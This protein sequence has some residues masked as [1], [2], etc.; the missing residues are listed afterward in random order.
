MDRITLAATSSFQQ[1]DGKEI[2]ISNNIIALENRGE[3]SHA[4]NHHNKSLYWCLMTRLSF[5]FSACVSL[6]IL[7]QSIY[8]IN[9]K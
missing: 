4:T 5:P 9:L 1:H 2:T 7:F 8:D 6:S 3:Q